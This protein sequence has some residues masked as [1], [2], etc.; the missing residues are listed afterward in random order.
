MKRVSVTK[1][2]LVFMFPKPNCAMLEHS[3]G[4][5]VSC[6]TPHIISSFRVR[7]KVCL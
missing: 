7:N 3:C 6:K 2:E 1:R 4:K 5:Q